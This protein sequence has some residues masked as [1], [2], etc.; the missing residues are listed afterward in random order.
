MSAALKDADKLSRMGKVEQ[1]KASIKENDFSEEEREAWKSDIAAA[2]KALEKQAMRAMV[3][4]TGERADGRSA[5]EDPTALYPPG[6]SA[7]RPRLRPVPAR[8]D[9]G[10]IRVHLGPSQ[11][12]AAS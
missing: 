10:A 8:S 1:L 3:I 6:I 4:E 11:R 5:D 7:P 2:C 9:P 12:G